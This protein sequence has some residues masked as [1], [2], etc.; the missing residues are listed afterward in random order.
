MFNEQ[1]ALNNWVPIDDAKL[2]T[3]RDEEGN[4]GNYKTDSGTPLYDASYKILDNA[5]AERDSYM[6]KGKKARFGVMIVSDGEDCKSE[7]YTAKK[8][9]EKVKKI[10]NENDPVYPNTISF[11][12]LPN[13]NTRVNYT[14]IAN[15]MGIENQRVN[16]RSEQVMQIITPDSD[17]T[18]IRRAFELFSKTSIR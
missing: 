7:R 16:K 13:Q 4:E 5:M 18:S 15:S 11:M 12:G 14:E 8:V 3:G 1:G 2:L 6:E 17:P 9:K 10:I